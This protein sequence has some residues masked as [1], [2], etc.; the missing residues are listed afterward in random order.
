MTNDALRQNETAAGDMA[1]V[2]AYAVRQ[3]E[4]AFETLVSRHVNLVYSAAVRQARD[5]HLA[6][7][8]TQAVFIILAR[9]AGALGADTI[10][11]SWLHRAAG[12][13]A[14]DALKIRRRRAQREQEAF[15]Q[16]ILNE[17]ENDPSSQGAA[18]AEAWRQIAP[19]LD[20]AIAGLNEKDRN[21]IVLRFFQDKSLSEIGAAL[22][23][24]EEAAK[25]RVNRALEKLRKYF[26]KR[27][28]SS[29][30]AMIAGTI[31]TNSIQAAPVALAKIVT[32]VAIV[33]G[34]TASTSTLT[35]IKGALKIM[36]WTKMKTAIVTGVAVL[37]TVGTTTVIVNEIHP[38]EPSYQG[39]KLSAW[40]ASLDTHPMMFLDLEPIT[41]QPAAEA[42]QA[43]G[44]KAV[45][46][47]RRELRSGNLLREKRAVDAA[48]AIGPAAKELIPDILP[49]AN[50]AAKSGRDSLNE[51]YAMA[52]LG[53]EAIGPLTSL[54]TNQNKWARIRAVSSFREVPYNADAAIPALL[55]ALSD[56]EPYV[57][58][59]AAP[60]LA[61]I[62]QQLDVVIPAL[63]KNLQDPDASVRG[64][65]A[66]ALGELGTD[67]KPAVPAL[68]PLLK[69]DDVG[70]RSWTTGALKMIDPVTAA[71]AGVK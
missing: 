65:T 29:T 53:P 16:T 57:R 1:L 7:E 28:V 6:G 61:H 54:F 64:I 40:L 10:L 27:G 45:P 30:T 33:K 62:H 3:S 31:S 68:I 17:P 22:G 41:N 13:A 71:Q 4:Q 50:A 44:V 47:L 2:R 59:E 32:A 23:A 39:Q 42:F 11:P 46:F 19:L 25:K 38:Q 63:V 35:L 20:A 18:E 48:R 67:G 51:I 37:L 60:A 70:V 55:N 52:A 26:S 36:A 21:A 34:A 49:V 58:S 15:M 12:F 56:P 66:F 14:A 5:P 24:S 69:D 8:I 9:K 43:M